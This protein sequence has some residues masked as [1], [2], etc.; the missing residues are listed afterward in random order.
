MKEEQATGRLIV[1]HARLQWWHVNYAK[2]LLVCM[3]KVDWGHG[4]GSGKKKGG[5]G[6]GKKGAAA[7][8]KLFEPTEEELQVMEEELQAEALAVGDGEPEAGNW[9]R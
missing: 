8:A 2:L 5:R 3:P 1:Q 9:P 7:A 4:S 6:G